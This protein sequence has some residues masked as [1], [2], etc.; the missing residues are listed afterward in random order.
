MMHEMDMSPESI[1]FPLKGSWY[2]TEKEQALSEDLLYAVQ[3]QM[4]PLTVSILSFLKGSNVMTAIISRILRH[5]SHHIIH[6][7]LWRGFTGGDG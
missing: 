5:Y 4:G 3:N 2:E 1:L 6:S 7:V